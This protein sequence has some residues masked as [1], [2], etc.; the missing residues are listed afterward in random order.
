MD[1]CLSIA[2]RAS[3]RPLRRTVCIGATVARSY[4]FPL[5]MASG[6]ADAASDPRAAVLAETPLLFVMAGLV[7]FARPLAILADSMVRNHAVIPGVTTLIRWQSHWHVI[8][9]SW[10]FFQNDFAGRI[11]NRVMNTS[12]SLRESV[13]SSIACLVH[14]GTASPRCFL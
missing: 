9:Q 13:V 3:S 5:F 4:R 12:N 2:L 6:G 8:R 7:L 11:A 14:V 10:N 1:C